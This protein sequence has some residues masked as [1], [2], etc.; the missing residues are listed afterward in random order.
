VPELPEVERYRV[1]LEDH[2]LGRKIARVEA[3]DAWYLKE[4]TDARALADALEGRSLVRAGRRGKLLVAG[5]EGGGT[6]GLRFGMTGR[7]VIDGR[8]GIDRL[9]YSPSSAEARWDRVTVHFADGGDLRMADP[10]RLGGVALDPDL[11]GLGPD[12]LRATLADVRVALEGSAVALKARLLDQARLAG[13]GNLVADELLWRAGLAPGRPAGGLG[14][15]EVRRLHRR[16]GSTLRML[17]QR[18][19]SHTGDL[20]PQRRAGGRCP[21]DGGPL[22]RATIGGRTTWWCPAHQH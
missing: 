2:G 8:A 21:A 7:L 19:G 6:L 12:A 5:I 3:A 17:V 18:G 4:G 15:E 10:R 22:R 20:A 1:L 9:L 14:E 11:G 13:V 16:L